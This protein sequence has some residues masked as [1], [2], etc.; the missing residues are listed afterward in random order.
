MKT[1]LLLSLTLLISGVRTGFAQKTEMNR[2]ELTKKRVFYIR[3]GDSSVTLKIDTLIM[4]TGARIVAMGKKNVIIIARYVETDKKCAV[5]GDDG[6][7]NG[8]NFD[9]RMNFIRL[10]GLTINASGKNTTGGNRNYPMGHGGNVTIHYLAS[11]L[12]PQINQRTA[13]NYILVNTEGGKGSI[14]PNTDLA[15]IQSQIRSG[16]TP[17]RPLSGLRNGTVFQGSDGNNGKVKLESVE[18]L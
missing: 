5:S 18:H 16:S 6:R 1:Y 17:G 4:H 8:T 7:N 3:G 11:G 9:L 14:S 12:K 15:V 10:N 2:L 13:E